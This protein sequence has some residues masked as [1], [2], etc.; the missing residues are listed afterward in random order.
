M[1]YIKCLFFNFL[2]IFFA[3]HIIPGIY[4]GDLTKIPHIRADLLFP[5]FLGLI[6][7]WIYP[8]LRIFDRSISWFHIAAL[9]V[10]INF[11]SYAVLK[12]ISIGIQIVT[13]EGYLFVSIIVSVGSFVLNYWEMKHCLKISKNDEPGIPE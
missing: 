11:V 8:A 7:S 2:I 6:N 9:A 5:L 10:V 1:N 3:N 13:L 4:V 12:I